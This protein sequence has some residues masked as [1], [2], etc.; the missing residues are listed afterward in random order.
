MLYEKVSEIIE[1]GGSCGAGEEV[2]SWSEGC[3]DLRFSFEV[4]SFAMCYF[5]V[6]ATSEIHLS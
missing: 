6:T 5:R 2:L 3:V 4:V 1:D